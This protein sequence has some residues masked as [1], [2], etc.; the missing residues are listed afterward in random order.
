[1]AVPV[2]LA[3]VGVQCA[4]NADGESAFLCGVQQVVGRQS[5]QMAREPAVD[6]KQRPQGVRE[7]EGA[8]LAGR[9]GQTS[10]HRRNP[11]IGGLFATGRA[12]PPVTALVH[13]AVMRTAAVLTAK[14]PA[15]HQRRAAGQHLCDDLNL[16][17]PERVRLYDVSPCPVALEQRFHWPGLEGGIR[18]SHAHQ[19]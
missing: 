19:A 3:T 14:L 17:V 5:K 2:K 7:R 18:T 10:H 6:G 1:M 13:I 12:S 15:A 8:V 16:H 9:V 4:K 11:D